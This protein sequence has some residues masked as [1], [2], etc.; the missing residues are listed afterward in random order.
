[1]QSRDT[2]LFYWKGLLEQLLVDFKQNKKSHFLS[3]L[4]GTKKVKGCTNLCIGLNSAE[5]K[6]SMHQILN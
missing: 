4:K 5:E 1:M 2:E 3:T 6:A